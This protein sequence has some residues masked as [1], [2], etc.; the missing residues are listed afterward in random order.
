M[1]KKLELKPAPPIGTIIKSFQ[2]WRDFHKQYEVWLSQIKKTIKR[3]FMAYT[4]LHVDDGEVLFN[5]RG[6]ISVVD[7][8]LPI[9]FEIKPF[10]KAQNKLPALLPCVI[11]TPQEASFLKYQFSDWCKDHCDKESVFF[12]YNG[13]G[14]K[15]KIGE[16]F[17]KD[18][19]FPWFVTG[20]SEELK[21][22]YETVT[23]FQVFSLKREE[24]TAEQIEELIR[25][26]EEHDRKIREAEN[27][28]RSQL[29][30]HNF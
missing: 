15:E 5:D 19:R 26:I 27:R 8:E 16:S 13:R 30:S 25:E 14:E 18:I 3:P 7:Y 9:G 28:L 20:T 4:G 21:P 11:R 22:K 23:E 12:L 24:G 2:E 10:E 29:N 1:F 6:F 17:S